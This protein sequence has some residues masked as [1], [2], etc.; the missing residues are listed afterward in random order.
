MITILTPSY[1]RAHTLTRLFESLI[2]Q[3]NQNFEW[4]IVDDGSHDKTFD[5]VSDFIGKNK[6]N[7]KYFFQENKGKPSAV[8]FGVEKASG[9]YIFIVDSDDLLPAD[10]IETICEKIKFHE[11]L[12][13]TFS[14]VCF[15]KSTLDGR[16]LGIDFKQN[17]NKFKYLNSTELKNLFNVDL[18]YIF[19]RNVMLEY[20]FP[21]FDNENF[22]P[23]LYIWNKITDYAKVYAYINKSIYLCEYLPDGLTANFKKQLRKNPR[24]FA[25]YYKN[26]FKRESNLIT[27]IK[28]FIRLAQCFLYRN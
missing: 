21:F 8:N 1:N 20:P 5:L 18:A 28:I 16:L 11:S 14:G 24:G 7:I 17:E 10:S 2:Q 6:I 19:K 15:R 26:Q 4:L 25:L 13:N 22:V 12:N 3:S 23:E 9:S 27:K